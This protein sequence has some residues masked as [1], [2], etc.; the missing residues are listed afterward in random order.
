MK[1]LQ[2][3]NLRKQYPGFLLNDVSFEAYGGEITKLNDTLYLLKA[4]SQKVT[5][6][7]GE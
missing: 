2:V 7:R 5:L 4:Q 6:I 1:I 3:Q